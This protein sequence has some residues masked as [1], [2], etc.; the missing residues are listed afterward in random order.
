MSNVSIKQVDDITEQLVIQNSLMAEMVRE[1]DPE[2]GWDVLAR[3]ADQGLFSTLYGIGD[4]FEDTWKD[5][6][7]NNKEYTFPWRFNHISDVTLKDGTVLKNRPYLQLAY[8][9]PFGVQFSHQRAITFVGWKATQA[10]TRGTKYYFTNFNGGQCISFTAPEDVAIGQFL[11]YNAGKIEIWGTDLNVA[12]KADATL[13]S[14]GTGTSLGNAP[15]MGAGEYYFTFKQNWGNNVKAGDVVSFSIPSTLVF[16]DRICGCY[17]APDQARSTWKVY[18]VTDD[19]KTI[20]EAI[21]TGTSTSG[22]SLGTEGYDKHAAAGDYLLNS[23]QEIAYGHNRWATSAVR[24]YLNS[25][26]GVGAWWTAQDALDV[27]PDELATKAGFLT[28]MSNAMLSAIK[29]VKVSTYAN[30]T[31]DGGVEDITYDRVFLPSLTEMFIVPQANE[32][33]VHEYW[34]R[35][36]GLESPAT[37]YTDRPEYKTYAVE[38][39][40]NPVYVRSR[41]ASRDR[42]SNAWYVNPSGRVSSLYARDAFRF[43]PLVVLSPESTITPIAGA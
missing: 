33:E 13:S 3:R 22:T 7:D 38:N 21:D 30:T 12:S 6:A 10:L 34:R 25:D 27:R 11:G 28:G 18:V 15:T 23:I 16:G 37:W 26:A 4:Q 1:N 41:S 40:T 14:T 8:A 35:R 20:G 32:G 5:V 31:Q 29:A 24:Q 42:A 17:F 2:I 36:S 43:A 19:G 9:T 39:H